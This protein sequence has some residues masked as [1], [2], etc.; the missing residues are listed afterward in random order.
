MDAAHF[1]KKWEIF[2][3][4][5]FREKTIVCMTQR[6]VSFEVIFNFQFIFF[7]IENWPSVTE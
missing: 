5:F 1:R 7:R 3:A 6:S 2:L 4:R